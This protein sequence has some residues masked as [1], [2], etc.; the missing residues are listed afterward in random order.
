MS[1][2]IHQINT[3]YSLEAGKLYLKDTLELNDA[4]TL[5]KTL[6]EKLSGYAG[7]HLEINLDFLGKVDSSGV[8]AIEYL[9]HKLEEK[10]IEIQISGGSESIR[11]KM[12]IFHL[13]SRRAN[14]TYL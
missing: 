7:D 3:N 10:G 13:E 8:M 14:P 11:E 2:K 4:A 1:K 6:L 9:K 12:N 5:V